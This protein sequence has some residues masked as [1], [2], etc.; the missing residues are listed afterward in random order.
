M[1]PSGMIMP[2]GGP[3]SDP[4][5][6]LRRKKIAVLGGAGPAAGVDFTQKLLKANQL[7][8]GSQRYRSDRD[9]PHLTLFQVPGLGGPRGPTDLIDEHLD[10][11][12]LVWGCLTDTILKIDTMGCDYFLISCNTLHILEE[13][14]EK[15]CVEKGI[16]AKFCSVIKFVCDEIADSLVER[17]A[18]VLDNQG[19]A[20]VEDRS[21]HSGDSSQKT[22]GR[23][24]IL[25][26]LPVTDVS[27]TTD[28]HMCW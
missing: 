25:G 28:I 27:C 9:A 2:D 15:W 24:C 1:A 17:R 6:A 21:P 26:S 8:L 18:S 3:P 10:A 16:R 12:K 5:L 4:P 13:K 14:I 7:L 11:Y 23:V 20:V 22:L 19:G